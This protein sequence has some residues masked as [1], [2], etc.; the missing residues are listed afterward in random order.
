MIGR[1]VLKLLPWWSYALLAVGMLP[2]SAGVIASSRQERAELAILRDKPQP[3]MVAIASFDP[4]RDVH[5]LGEVHL[6][7]IWRSDLNVVEF[8]QKGVNHSYLLLSDENDVSPLVALHFPSYQRDTITEYL[9]AN[10]GTNGRVAVGGFIADSSADVSRVEQDLLSRGLS[11]VAV[12]EPFT[13]SRAAAVDGKSTDAGMVVAIMAA[14]NAGLA[15]VALVKFRSWRARVA[16]R[17]PQSATIAP[18]VPAASPVAKTPTKTSTAKPPKTDF[19]DGP[20]FTKK[21]FFR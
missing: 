7:G 3:P 15:L 2:L 4:E 8:S 19:A 11:A 12:I 9:R 13:G 18:S 16:A 20:I 5:A 17:R 1:I 21:G 14:M 10:T 6:N